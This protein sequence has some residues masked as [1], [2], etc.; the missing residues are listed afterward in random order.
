MVTASHN[1]P[2]YNGFKI[3]KI[4]AKPVGETSGLA[5]VRKFAATAERNTGKPGT[6]RLESRDL[7]DA[8]A[9]HV[10]SFLDLGTRNLKVVIDASNGMAGT[11]LPKIFGKKACNIE[12][13]EFVEINFDNSKGEFAHEPNPLVAC[14][15]EQTQQAVL[16]HKADLGICFDGDADRLVVV[17]ETGAII[18]CDHL[19]TLLAEYFLAKKPGAGVIYDLRSTKA[20]EE[21]IREHGGE[22][23]RSRVGHVFMK[24]VMAERRAVFGGELSGHF[25]FRKN[26][27]ADSGAIA[28]ATLLTVL[29]HTHK[30]MSQ[31]IAPARKYF[32]SGEINFEIEEQ[33]QALDALRENYGTVAEIDELDGVTIDAFATD[34]WWFNVRK[35]NTEPLLR[36][37]AEARSPEELAR[38]ID[39]LSPMLGVRVAH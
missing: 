15:L 11:M 39:E 22:P 6:G 17:D 16:E 10:L 8:Y 20:V 3:S 23:I 21:T 25:Y 14:N 34:G 18:G 1:P 26:Y 33:D 5:T 19:T 29:S 35:S 27:N 36:L 30:T 13:V 38:I 2:Q 4:N 37:N 31:L 32:Q 28:L 24:Q 7:W 9:A 12:G